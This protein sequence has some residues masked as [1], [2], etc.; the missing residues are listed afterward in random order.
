VIP[1]FGDGVTIIEYSDEANNPNGLYVRKKVQID[2]TNFAET[3]AYF[4]KLGRTVKTQAKD[5]Q[6][7]IFSETQ[8]DLMG[9]V[10]KVSNPYRQGQTLL[11]TTT[12]YDEAGRVKEVITPD[13]AKVQTS[14]S[15]AIDGNEVGVVT[16]GVDQSG[17]QGRSVT[18]A[19]GRLIRV[20]EPNGAGELGPVNNPNQATYYTYDILGNLRKVTQGSQQRFFAYDSLSRLIRA[21]NVEQ[22][23][24]TNLAPYTDPVT[25]NNQ[26]SQSFAYDAN[27]NLITQVTARNITITNS[28]DALNR[29]VFRDYSDSTPDVSYFYD[30]TGLDQA[31]AF[32]KGKLTKAT[33]G[34]SENRFTSFDAVGRLLTSEQIIDGQS[35]PFVYAY[36]N[37]TGSLISETYPSGRVITNSFD[38]LERLASVSSKAGP[39]QTPRIY[40]NGFGYNDKGVLNRM[41]LGN[42]LWESVKVNDRF[43]TT[44][45]SLG[46]SAGS[47]NR[48]KLEY[49]YGM[50]QN[51]GNVLS[52]KITVPA[53]G[54]V[55][56]FVAVQSYEY[57]S[58][59]R[60]KSAV[61]TPYGQT[62]ENWRQVFDYDRYG[63]RTVITENNA[64][65]ASI[66]GPNPQIDTSTNRIVP[67]T[68]TTEQYQFDASGNMTRDA[69]GNLFTFDAENHQKTF[70]QSGSATGPSA[71]YY[72]DGDGR[73][74]KKVVG[75]EVTYF[76]YDASGALAEEYTQNIPQNTNPQTIYMTAD[77]LGSPRINTNQKGEVVARHDY[78]PFGDEIVGLG[79]RNAEQKYAV[80]DGVRQKFTGYQKDEETGLDFAQARYYGNG[81]GRF[82]S[83]DPAIESI[84]ANLPQS[85]NRYVY[86]LNNPLRYADPDGMKPTDPWNRLTKEER[87]IIE[88]KLILREGQTYQTVFNNM[89]TNNNTLDENSND[90]IENVIAISNVIKVLGGYNNSKSWQLIASI[91]GVITNKNH[92]VVISVIKGKKDDFAKAL[93]AEKDSQGRP[94]YYTDNIIEK[95]PGGHTGYST[96]VF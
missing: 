6:G 27:G 38:S 93:Q 72:Y 89:V 60:L 13:N 18:D 29:A 58:L 87:E 24:N 75:S 62:T 82:T 50:T 77:V 36:N 65:T 2:A 42:G 1:P 95:K 20:D 73:R 86:V 83:V 44:E 16:T 35:Y 22:E 94:K 12:T 55:S 56:G 80:T 49:D 14:Y 9:R 78:L 76:I 45:I 63:N 52:Q 28:Y 21:K 3:T 26:W 74:V 51:N 34:V 61:E 88:K 32:S 33:N 69:V 10:W 15:L 70:T 54:T 67:K 39:A 64:T 23:T 4:D 71:T 68:N 90:V 96:V 43:Q 46:T 48:L 57:D 66:V 79:Q 53:I 41:R 11:W 92:M 19:L 31:P 47:G 7:D 30:G 17:K 81:L 5:S 8:Y 85:W 40:A 25:G 91:D 84:K 37:I 59:N